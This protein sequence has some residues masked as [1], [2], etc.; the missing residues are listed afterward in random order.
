VGWNDEATWAGRKCVRC[1]SPDP[2]CTSSGRSR[3]RSGWK[4]DDGLE[5][6]PPG[7]NTGCQAARNL[8]AHIPVAP[9]GPPRGFASLRQ[10]TASPGST[11]T[12][13][14]TSPPLSASLEQVPDADTGSPLQGVP[15][16]RGQ[17]EDSVGR[18][19]EAKWEGKSRGEWR[20]RSWVPRRNCLCFSARP[21]LH[22]IRRLGVGRAFVLSF[23]SFFRFTISFVLF[24]FSFG[25]SLVR[26]YS[27]LGQAWA[28]GKGEFATYRPRADS[29]RETRTKMCAAIVY[30]G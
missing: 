2:S 18:S 10:V 27:F 9:R 25:V 1:R 24:P 17:A 5:A 30:M 14:R 28:E 3:R 19:A 29:G 16:V 21:L 7:R 20:P 4:L 12:G 13:R 22:G 23:C 6:G 11:S 15:R 26:N 8:M